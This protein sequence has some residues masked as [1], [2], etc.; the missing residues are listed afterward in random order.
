MV[1]YGHSLKFSRKD[2]DDRKATR[3]L[4]KTTSFTFNKNSVRFC[5]FLSFRIGETEIR[6]F[7][8]LMPLFSGIPINLLFVRIFLCVNCFI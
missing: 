6:A 2:V 4:V 1:L 3:E 8:I 5:Q 7:R